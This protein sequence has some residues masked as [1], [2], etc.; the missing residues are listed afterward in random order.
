MRTVV[1]MAASDLPRIAE[2]DRSEHITQQ[3]RSRGARLELVE[4][5]IRAP[6]WGDPGEHS[7]EHYVDQ[8]K[9]VLD[10]GGVLFGAFEGDRLVGFAIYDPSLAKDRGQLLELYVTRS[11]RGQG[12]GRRLIGEV[13]RLA[14]DRGARR[15]YVSATPTRRTVDFYLAQGFEVLATPDPR[16]DALEPDDIHLELEL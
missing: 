13:A 2:I 3:Y 15:L 16:L 9:T 14:R 6:R 7:V 4:V 5:D 10:R 11:H 8:W 12:T 1:E